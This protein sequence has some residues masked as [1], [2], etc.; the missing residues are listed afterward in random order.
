MQKTKKN[1]GGLNSHVKAYYKFL[2]NQ[3]NLH[4]IS[5]KNHGIDEYIT[6][7]LNDFLKKGKKDDY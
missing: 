2:E 1:L 3:K 7:A 4:H 6:K 5:W